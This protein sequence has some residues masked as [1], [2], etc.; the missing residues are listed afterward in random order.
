MIKILEPEPPPPEPSFVISLRAVD[1]VFAKIEEMALA[2]L[3]MTLIFLAVYQAYKRNVAPP[4]PYWPDELIRYSVFYIG[5]LG[6]ALASQSDRLINIDMLTR[7]FSPRGKLIIRLVT[8]AFTLGV[9]VLLVKGGF[10]VRDINVQLHEEG[11]LISPATGIL[12]LPVGAALIG[13]HLTL[14]AVIDIY[15][16]AT[17]RK[18]PESAP[19]II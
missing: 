17:G 1:R 6:A 7:L 10:H 2:A 12:A 18:P 9:C 14:H 8:T 13:F 11:E 19:V 15:Y 4:S 5:L 16:L 3:L